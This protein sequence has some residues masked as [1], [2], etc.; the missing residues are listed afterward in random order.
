[1]LDVLSAWL[2]RA[3]EMH[4]SD[5]KDMGQQIEAGCNR[6]L[7]IVVDKASKFLFA[8]PL[9]TNEKL[10][11]AATLLDVVL[12]FG[13]MISLRSYPGAEITFEVVGNLCQWLNLCIHHGPADL[14][15]G[16]GIFQRLVGCLDEALGELCK[17]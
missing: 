7:L 14:V 4:E 12:T 6:Y 1:M 3:E 16:Q 11:V 9:P 15:R 17:T 10:G 2:L 5:A 8:F 13:L